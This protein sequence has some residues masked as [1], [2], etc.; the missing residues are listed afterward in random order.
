MTY[1]II[2]ITAIVSIACLRDRALFEKL[3][4]VPYM[5]S[6]RRQWYRVITHIF[7]HGD[8]THLIVNM[9]VLWSFGQSIETMFRSLETVGVIWNGPLTFL[10]LYFLGGIAAS[11]QD[12]VKQRN[13]PYYASIGASGSVAAV[14]FAWIFFN[15]WQKLYLFGLVPIPG[16]IFGV[17]Y[18]V[19]S[20]YMGGRNGGNINHYAHL[21]GALFGFIFPMLIDPS[22][23]SA[24]FEKLTSF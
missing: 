14:I 15:P 5:V 9:L 19:Y 13:N 12:L 4:L 21:Y 16:I 1:I 2:F 3:S 22:M 11:I 6:R 7:V 24:F 20:R 17:L 18:L 8:Y 23:I 10:A